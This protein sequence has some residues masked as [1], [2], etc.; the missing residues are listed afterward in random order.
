MT[1]LNFRQLKSDCCIFKRD[2]PFPLSFVA[3]HVDDLIPIAETVEVMNTLKAD[4]AKRFPAKDLGPLHYV[5][6]ISC[7]QDDENA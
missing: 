1:E 6:G 7:I 3:L 5:L 4:I 2:H